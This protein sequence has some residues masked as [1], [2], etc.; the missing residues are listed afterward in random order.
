VRDVII[1]A[2]VLGVLPFIFRVPAVGAYLWAW[3]SMMNPHKLT[4]GFAY[5]LPFAQLTAVTTLLVLPFSK[6]RKPFPLNAVSAVQLVLLCWMS[7]TAL[8]A[9][10][11][12]DVVLERWIFVMKIQ[13]MLFA[14]LMLVRGRQQI[15]TLVWIVTLSIGFYGV[16]GGVWTV[17][18]GGGG[19]VWGPPGG[20]IE[21]NNELAVALVML[22]PFM[23]Y[24]YRVSTRR[25]VRIGLGFSLA[26]TAFAVLGT[27]SRGALLAL[28][29][30]S[31][32]LGL[33]SR[34][35]I[36]ATFALAA[37]LAIVITFMPD[38]WVSRMETMQTYEEEG[39]AMSRLY[40]WTTLWNAAQDRPILGTGFRA[41][42]IE[43]FERYAPTEPKWA[44]FKGA[45]WV[46]HSIYFQMLGEQGFVGLAIFL[47]LFG[48]AWIR[49]GTLAKITK[50]DPE[51]GS[52]VP[53]LMPMVQ[54]SL[55]GYLV[56]GAFLSLAYFDL[57]YYI[58]AY[59]ILV[60]ATVRE[61]RRRAS[62]LAPVASRAGWAKESSA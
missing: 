35:K 16:K 56:G 32:I 29:A 39:S 55:A 23:A 7:F 5:N 14:T 3:L 21:G 51:F 27:Q 24:L 30:M 61:H 4:Y 9:L 37:A 11:T 33:K 58:I 12:P 15:E 10:N 13:V 20:M 43:I 34:Y 45:V 44:M 8:F 18:T 26:T 22:M 6:Q 50:D 28:V 47:I 49:A 2:I 36:R 54:V 52:W 48:L 53:L 40:T 60:D 46:A 59:V 42:S 57:P 38:S 1:T 19:R 41:D 62:A 25:I 17:L 31:A